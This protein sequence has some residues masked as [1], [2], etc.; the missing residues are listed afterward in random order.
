MTKEVETPTED[1][2]YNDEDKMKIYKRN[3]KACHLLIIRL[4]DI[5][6]GLVWQC[7]DNSH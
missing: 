3:S 5:S 4:I 1:E 7:D 2:A 6:Y